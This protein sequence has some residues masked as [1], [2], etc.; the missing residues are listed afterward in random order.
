MKKVKESHW[1][2]GRLEWRSNYL[3]GKR[4]GLSEWWYSDGELGWRGSFLNGKRKG[5]NESWR[6]NDCLGKDYHLL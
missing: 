3:N 6:Y 4:H 5:L 2:N 1:N